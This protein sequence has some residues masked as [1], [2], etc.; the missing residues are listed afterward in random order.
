M[1]YMNILR[2]QDLIHQQVRQLRQ[3][4]D[5]DRSGRAC[6]HFYLMS[7]TVA[8]MELKPRTDKHGLLKRLPVKVSNKAH[9]PGLGKPD[10]ERI[11]VELLI[12]HHRE[13]I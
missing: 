13:E 8:E 4:V 1:W 9:E 10:E 7:G 12:E 2:V 5:P 11:T 6:L 3:A